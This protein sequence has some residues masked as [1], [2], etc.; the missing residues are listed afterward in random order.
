MGQYTAPR[1]QL[2]PPC[3]Q[4]GHPQAHLDPGE[5]VLGLAPVDAPTDAAPMDWGVAPYWLR[6]TTGEGR[7]GVGWGVG[8]PDLGWARYLMSIDRV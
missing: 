6:D 8:V 3:R 4:Q 5:V 7:C 1:R 2:W